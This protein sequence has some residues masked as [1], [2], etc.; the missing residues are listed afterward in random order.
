MNRV[1]DFVATA[2]I[3]LLEV[4]VIAIFLST[5]LTAAAL[6]TGAL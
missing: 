2:F 4:I 1:V 3:T 5:I 6:W